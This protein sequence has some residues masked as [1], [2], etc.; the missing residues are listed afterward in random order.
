MHIIFSPTLGDCCNNS[1]LDSE[2][3]T[4]ALG[5]I[6]RQLEDPE[7]EVSTTIRGLQRKSFGYLGIFF[8]SPQRIT[9]ETCSSEWKAQ[10]DWCVNRLIRKSTPNRF[11]LSLLVWRNKGTPSEFEFF[12]RGCERDAPDAT[13]KFLT[14]QG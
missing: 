3:L 11:P 8:T 10:L 6:T 5:R 13:L 14:R 4:Q 7:S 1:N 2:F 12:V 9:V